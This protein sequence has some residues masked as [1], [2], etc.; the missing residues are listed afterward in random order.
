[1]LSTCSSPLVRLKSM[2]EQHSSTSGSTDTPTN[3]WRKPAVIGASAALGVLLVAGAVTG[4]AFAIAGNN[5]D[6]SNVSTASSQSSPKD[7]AASAPT[8]PETGPTTEPAPAEDRAPSDAASLSAAITTAVAAANGVGA[9][10]IEVQRNGW[11]VEVQRN[12]GTEA[13]VLVRLDGSTQVRDEDDND[14]D[15]LIEVAQLPELV[16]ISLDTAGGGSIEQ[17]STDDD[18]DYFYEVEVRM[19]DDSETEVKLDASLNV[20]DVDFD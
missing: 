17:I 14:D 20:L 5:S 8:V 10:Q 4:V 16:R 6:A 13:E 3:F 18:G 1:M 2:S 12:D 19:E 7:D 9:T 15:P 11:E